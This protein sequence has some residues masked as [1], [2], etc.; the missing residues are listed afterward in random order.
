[1]SSQEKFEVVLIDYG[2]SVGL[3]EHWKEELPVNMPGATPQLSV[4]SQ[5]EWPGSLRLGTTRF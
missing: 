4:E 3:E 1:V 5:L 2:F